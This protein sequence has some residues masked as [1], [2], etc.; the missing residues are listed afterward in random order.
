M[1]LTKY[2][3]ACVFI[4]NDEVNKVVIDS[5]EWTELPEDLSNIVAVVC[6]HVHGDHTSAE[7]VQKIV[8]ANPEVVVYANS[9]SMTVLESVNCK[10]IVVDSDKL[11]NV[12]DFEL[13]LY[14][15]D[16]A[17]I[18]KNSPCKNLAVKVNDFYY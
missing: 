11:E 16:H 4:E 7:N 8:D 1:K 10:K 2:G 9:E 15:L 18:W 14:V 17:A 12:G 3:H 6:T 5:G 13:S